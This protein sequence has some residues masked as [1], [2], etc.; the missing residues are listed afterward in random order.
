MDYFV[1]DRWVVKNGCPDVRGC[2]CIVSRPV[3]PNSK[4]VFPPSSPGQN[5]INRG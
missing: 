2:A 5:T 3:L 4:V 1:D